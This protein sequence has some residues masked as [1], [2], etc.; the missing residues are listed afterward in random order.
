M[1]RRASLSALLASL[2]FSLRSS[3]ASPPTTAPSVSMDE[4]VPRPVW[5]ASAN[6]VRVSAARGPA[7]ATGYLLPGSDLVVTSARTV[8][9]ALLSSGWLESSAAASPRS[10]RAAWVDTAG[11]VRVAFADGRECPASMVTYDFGSNVGVLRLETDDSWWWRAQSLQ[12]RVLEVLT[13]RAAYEDRRE[14]SA[15]REEGREREE[16]NRL[17]RRVWEAGSASKLLASVRHEHMVEEESVS[18]GPERAKG[19]AVVGGKVAEG[20]GGAV[21]DDVGGDCEGSVWYE[22]GL[23]E[24]RGAAEVS[25]GVRE[26]VFGAV[27]AE[28]AVSYGRLGAEGLSGGWVDLLG[29]LEGARGAGGAV[30]R[31]S[32]AWSMWE[33]TADGTPLQ[34]LALAAKLVRAKNGGEGADGRDRLVDGGMERGG[35]WH[36]DDF[37][38]SGSA[39]TVAGVGLA[40]QRVRRGPLWEQ[41]VRGQFA[42]LGSTIPCSPV[43]LR[44]APREKEEEEEER[45]SEMGE[46]GASDSLRELVAPLTP[47]GER[48]AG[49]ALH[50]STPLVVARAVRPTAS[51]GAPVVDGRG[52]LRG[53]VVQ[54]APGVR[55]IVP[56]R[57][58]HEII[59]SCDNQAS[60][61]TPILATRRSWGLTALRPLRTGHVQV[62][63]VVRDS[64]AHR[65]GVLPGDVLLDFSSVPH[66]RRA[67]A[68]SPFPPALRTVRPSKM[69]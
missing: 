22:L 64:P 43:A 44:A 57:V 48:L 17:R 30:G 5:G 65:M 34:A 15:S 16:L 45:G 20:S 38:A 19:T 28:R 13:G 62:L 67:E 6:V 24:V 8:H 32:G 23:E 1:L 42:S 12:E 41:A 55:H 3:S 40:E 2:P 68:Q 61:G 14:K 36:G 9:D 18:K 25:A 53:M 7:Q 52:E 29:V 59:S 56:A 60:P 63:E 37:R 11:L 4:R 49:D 47:F 58:I 51:A 26:R 54:A 33:R 50:V 31:V 35:G 69:E 46:R 27:V 39:L 10:P 21:S 66:L